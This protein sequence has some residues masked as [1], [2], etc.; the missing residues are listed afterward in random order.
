[1]VKL[2]LGNRA[3]VLLLIPL[4]IVIYYLLNGQTEYYSYDAYSNLGLWGNSVYISKSL[5][6]YLSVILIGINAFFINWIYNKNE[7]LER[8]SYISSL[9]YVTLMSFYHSF[10]SLDGILIAHTALIAMLFQFFQLRQ[11]EDGRRH[12]F[13]G[14]FFAGVA[15]SFHPP[16]IV[17]FPIYLLMIYVARPVAFRETILAVVGFGIP[18]LYGFL[19]LLYAEHEMHLRI[20]EQTTNYYKKQNDF[21]ITSV[22][23]TLLFILGLISLR[24]KITKSSSRLKKL[25]QILWLMV[26]IG[27]L[28]GFFDFFMFGQVERFSFLVIPLSFYLSYAFGNKT[29]HFIAL[30]LFYATFVYSLINFFF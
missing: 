24:L 8:N 16:I 12:V 4:L 26:L 2:F 14:A 13:N 10:Y 25:I 1:M 21:L 23:F 29:Y 9:L 3:G 19:Y 17:L 20:L 15:A 27:V 11:N 18:L 22:L 28:F 5:N 30:G 6:S 7:F